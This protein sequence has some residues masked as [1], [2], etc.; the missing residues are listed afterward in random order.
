[1]CEKEGGFYASLNVIDLTFLNCSIC[2][3]IEKKARLMKKELAALCFALIWLM[4]L[5]TMT[6]AAAQKVKVVNNDNNPLPVYSVDDKQPFQWQEMNVGS[7]GGGS[8]ALAVFS[9]ALDSR[10][11]IEYASGNVLCATGEAVGFEVW[12][13]AGGVFARHRLP[14]I[15]LG[16]SGGYQTTYLANQSMILNADSGTDVTIYSVCNG[17][18]AAM[19]AAISGY[20]VSN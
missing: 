6:L 5:P 17:T 16:A 9:V 12:T 19:H 18:L 3:H 4:I 11:V 13:T 2:L 15:P 7:D 14:V 8:A 1:V 20:L 10:L